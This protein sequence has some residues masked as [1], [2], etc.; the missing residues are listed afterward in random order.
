MAINVFWLLDVQ[1]STVIDFFLPLY[2][3]KETWQMRPEATKEMETHHQ[4]CFE[5][6]LLLFELMEDD[7]SELLA[8][9]WLGTKIEEANQVS[10]RE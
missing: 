3:E 1:Q 5:L 10:E 2:Q 6:P 8:A 9:D 4:L 7:L